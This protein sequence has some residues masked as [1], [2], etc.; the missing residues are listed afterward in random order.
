MTAKGKTGQVATRPASITAFTKPNSVEPDPLKVWFG[1][2]KPL[3]QRQ[4]KKAGKRHAQRSSVDA[5]LFAQR[6]LL[7]AIELPIN[8]VAHG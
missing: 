8:E 4:Q 6:V 5:H 1:L 3:R 7:A 2:A